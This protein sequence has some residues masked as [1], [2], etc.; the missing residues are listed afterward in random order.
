MTKTKKE[1]PVN[2]NDKYWLTIEDMTHDGRGV[3][4]VDFY[5]IFIE[6]AIIGE[7]VEVKILKTTKKF[8]YGKV[9]QW[10]KKSP[11][12]VEDID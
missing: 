10:K 7:E 1:L 4:K 8:A 2:K 3:G 5:P 6:N 12:R 9:L 11:N